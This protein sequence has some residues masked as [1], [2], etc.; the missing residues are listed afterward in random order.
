MKHKNELNSFVSVIGSAPAHVK[1]HTKNAIDE[2]LSRFSGHMDEAH[3]S[4]LFKTEKAKIQ[5]SALLTC[6]INLATDNGHYHA[7]ATEYGHYPSVKK[8]L[9]TLQ[10]QIDKRL[11]KMMDRQ[12]EFTNHLPA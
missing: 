8:A 6:T 4:I 12:K 7:E 5:N 11:G 10:F 1:D 3:A 9:E 2:M